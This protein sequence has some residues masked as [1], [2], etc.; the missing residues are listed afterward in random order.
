MPTVPGALV[1]LVITGAMPAG[2]TVMVRVAVPVPV[3]FVAPRATREMPGP[4]GVPS[5]AP[6]RGFST[7]PAGRPVAV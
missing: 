3:A 2:A 7:N 1:G 6:V 4:V 5:M